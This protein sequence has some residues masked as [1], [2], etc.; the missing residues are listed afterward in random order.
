MEEKWK[1]IIN[2]EGYYQISNF[3][4]IRS[5]D[6]KIRFNKGYSIKKGKM[7]KPIL[8]KKGYYKVSLSKKQKEKRF[9]IHRLVAIHFIEN[10]LSKEQVNHKDGNKKNNRADNL[11]WCTNLENQ[12]HAIKNG[13]I[14]NEQRIQQAINMGII[15]RKPVAQYTKEGNLIKEYVSIKEA[16]ILTGINSRNICNCLSPNQPKSKSAGGYIW[17][18]IEKVRSDYK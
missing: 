16:S 17:K 6:R 1:D 5:L 14:D 3:G 12:R 15:N 18:Y 4:N 13:L 2:Y 10:P 9:F 7:L 8:N 11:E